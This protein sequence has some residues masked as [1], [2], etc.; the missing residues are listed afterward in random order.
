LVQVEELDGSARYFGLAI[1]SG[2]GSELAVLPG[3][4]RLLIAIATHPR[5]S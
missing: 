4:I 2:T 1:E 3:L 5:W